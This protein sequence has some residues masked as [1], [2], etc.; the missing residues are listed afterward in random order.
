MGRSSSADS[1][2]ST[3][4]AGDGAHRARTPGPVPRLGQIESRH[5]QDSEQG[6]GVASSSPGQGAA[7]LSCSSL[8]LL[9]VSDSVD[10]GQIR[11]HITHSNHESARA[12]LLRPRSRRDFVFTNSVK[13]LALLLSPSREYSRKAFRAVP[14]GLGSM[15]AA[16][17]KCASGGARIARSRE[18]PARCRAPGSSKRQT[19]RKGGTQSH[20]SLF[21]RGGIARL[22]KGAAVCPGSLGPREHAGHL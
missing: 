20:G 21:S 22:P 9:Y 2:A 12:Y 17:L 18:S 16:L 19:I 3:T 8:F 10:N 7:G 1:S 15:Q 5:A 13:R 6:C 4:S 14:R 11:S